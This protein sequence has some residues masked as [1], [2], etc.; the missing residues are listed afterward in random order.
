MTTLLAVR[1]KMMDLMAVREHSEAELRAKLE[2]KFGEIPEGPEAIEAALEYGREKKWLADPAHLAAQ[3]AEALHRKGKGIAFINHY[4][5]EKGL[6]SIAMDSELE[7]EKARQL[8]KN[9]HL[10]TQNLNADEKEA[11]QAKLARFLTSRGFDE[12][13]LRKVIYEEL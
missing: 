10:E 13:T 6:P 7:L 1:R 5:E 9:K 4:L 3:T 2:Q 11:V 12:D 8:V